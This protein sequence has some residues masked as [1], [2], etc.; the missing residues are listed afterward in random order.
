[1]AH[2][3]QTEQTLRHAIEAMRLFLDPCLAIAEIRE[4][5]AHCT[6]DELVSMEAELERIV[7]ARGETWQAEHRGAA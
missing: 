5:V 1:M 2:T 3:E 6:R 7:V 4:Q